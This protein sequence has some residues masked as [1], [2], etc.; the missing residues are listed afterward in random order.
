M[1]FLFHEDDLPDS[2]TTRPL[3]P[4]LFHYLPPPWQGEVV[5][6]SYNE[7]TSAPIPTPALVR[8]Q[9]EQMVQSGIWPSHHISRKIEE[10]E[11]FGLVCPALRDLGGRRVLCRYDGGQDT[12][13]TA[14][15]L[16]ECSE[17]CISF[18]EVCDQLERTELFSALRELGWLDGHPGFIQ[19]ESFLFRQVL[20]YNLAEAWV[21]RLLRPGFGTGDYR[22]F[23]QCWVDLFQR[24]IT[25]D[26]N[27][28]PPVG[29]SIALGHGDQ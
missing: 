3:D 26:P 9:M 29:P 18:V 1:P 14:C 6:A 5:V 15:E 19:P 11:L 16:L 28:P 22:L 8:L 10:E 25:D 27:A 4:G 13:W 20:T 2:P 7:V 17:A 23:G 24:T 21:E 12:Q